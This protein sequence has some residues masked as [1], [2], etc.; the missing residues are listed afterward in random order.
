MWDFFLVFL[1]LRCVVKLNSNNEERVYQI[2]VSYLF[3]AI[4]IGGINLTD[5]HF[6]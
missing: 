6:D 3:D 5:I 4:K 2:F 1:D